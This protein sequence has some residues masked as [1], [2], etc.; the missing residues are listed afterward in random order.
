MDCDSNPAPEGMQNEKT[1]YLKIET[2]DNTPEKRFRTNAKRRCCHG[3]NK[4]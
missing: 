2:W 1:R 3:C 4:R